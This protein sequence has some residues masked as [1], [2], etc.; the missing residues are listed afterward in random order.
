MPTDYILFNHGVNNRSAR[1][2]PTYADTLFDL[3]Q[4]YSHQVHGRSLKKI[5]LYWGDVNKDE[6]Q[7]LLAA[8]Q[9]SPIWEHL[10]FRPFREQQLMQFIGDGALY[11]SRYAGAKVA[12]RLM[13]QSL[14]GLQN[15]QPQEDRMHLVTHS[16]GTVIL[17]DILFSARWDPDAVPGHASVAAIR[18]ALFGVAPNPTQGIRLSSISTMGSPIGFFSLTDVNSST[19]DA[20]DANGNILSTHDVTPR[21]EQ[22]LA[23]L[24]QELGQKLLWYNFVHPGDPIAYPLEKLLPQLLDGESKYIQAQDILTNLTSLTDVL[25]DPLSQT[26][27]ALLHGGEAHQSYWTSEQVA[28]KI[29]EAIETAASDTC[30]EDVA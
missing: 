5:A 9:A 6:E 17:F 28:Q 3:I 21:M 2:E 8:Y 13:E 11:L 15:Y 26:L 27:F 29:A 16:M 22:M 12:D 4:E 25:I 30:R 7:C 20:T 24:Y 18:Q 10:W 23:S 19:Q 14:M 1:P